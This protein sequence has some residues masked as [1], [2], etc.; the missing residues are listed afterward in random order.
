VPVL[1]F[2]GIVREY[3]GLQDVLVA[4][5]EIRAQL[6]RVILLIAGEFWEDKRP[7]LGLIEQLRIGD[8]VIIEDKYIPN[9]DVAVYFSAADV[10]VAPYRR[11][12]GSGVVQMA[13]GFGAPVITT[14]VSGGVIKEETEGWTHFAI[15]PM[16][17]QSL[18]DAILC[19]FQANHPAGADE[20][21]P[22][23]REQFSWDDLVDLIAVMDTSKGLTD[24]LKAENDH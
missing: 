10:L 1:L 8:S 14:N 23:Y 4:L 9:E 24:S 20:S 18:A 17:P 12:T 6:G 2:F 16:D 13:R 5:P 3:K 19:F 15:P 21:A 7:Y 22:G 11:A